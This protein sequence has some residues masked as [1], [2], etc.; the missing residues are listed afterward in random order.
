QLEL[1]DPRVFIS[2]FDRPNIKYIIQDRVDELKQL[3]SFIKKHH[4]DDTGIVYCLSRKKVEKV[5]EYLAGQGYFALPYHAGLSNEVRKKN[6]TLFSNE[7]KI[8]VVATIAFGMG[9]DRPDVRFVAHLDLPKSVENYYQETGRAGRDGRESTAWMLYGLQDVVKLSQMLDS[10]EAGEQYKKIARHKLDSMLFLCETLG[11]RRHYLLNYFGE[12]SPEKCA[13]CDSC[14]EP[15]E[16]FDATEDAQKVLSV[17]Y[18]T[19]QLYGANY[20]IDVLRGGAN[21]RISEKGHEKLS[22]Y[23]IGK[24]KSRNYW[25][26]II[27]QLLNMGY[28]NIKDWEYRS[29][30]LTEKSR[31][32]LT[33]AK[34]LNLRTIK[35]GIKKKKEKKQKQPEQSTDRE[36]FEALRQLRGELAQKHNVPPYIIFSDKTLHEMCLFKPGNNSELLMINGVGQAKLENYGAA[37]L[38]KI[39][40]YS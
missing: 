11:C 23:G 36:M 39:A 30:T 25:S 18:R 28:I 22:V 19:G 2:S 3:D 17:I 33:S 16:S 9:I 37:F 14:F 8:I 20:I 38:E 1:K 7:E 27:R 40:D 5:A 35:A 4:P 13:N 29:L 31:D 15:A 21:A 24:D 10:T 26:S 32:I 12:T 34:I 6:Q